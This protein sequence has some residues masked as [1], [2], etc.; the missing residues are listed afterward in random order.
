MNLNNLNAAV[1][2]E[3]QIFLFK[4]L[5][6]FPLEMYPEEGLLDHMAVLFFIF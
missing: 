2:M 6:S 4:I 3:V 1:N 5:I